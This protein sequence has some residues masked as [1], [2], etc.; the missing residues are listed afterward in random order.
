MNVPSTRVGSDVDPAEVDD[1]CVEPL[2]DAQGK[3]VRPCGLKALMR[4]RGAPLC[5][6][7][8]YRKTGDNATR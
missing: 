7:H 2:R 3:A 6:I 5:D 4:L 1:R 8:F